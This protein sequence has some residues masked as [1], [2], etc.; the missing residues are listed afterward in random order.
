[1]SRLTPR[2]DEE[3]GGLSTHARGLRLWPA[4]ACRDQR[5]RWG[6]FS[7]RPA[8]VLWLQVLVWATVT[9]HLR[10]LPRC[11]PAPL[12]PTSMGS[13]FCPAAAAA[14]QAPHSPAQTCRASSPHATVAEFPTVHLSPPRVTSHTASLPLR[15]P[16]V[17]RL[18]TLVPGVPL[19]NAFL[20]PHGPIRLPSFSLRTASLPHVLGSP[21]PL[22]RGQA[23]GRTGGLQ[24]PCSPS[25]N[26]RG[27]E[28]GQ[29]VFVGR[30]NEE[31]TRS[32][33][34]HGPWEVEK[35]A[36]TRPVASGLLGSGQ[37]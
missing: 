29:D 23:P 1:M 21:C 30:G 17:L 19:G 10:E 14:S 32:V 20:Q 5:P 36:V 22:A 6:S 4:R 26:R 11:P 9:S 3:T 8:P 33:L 34:S 16:P 15:T 25:W 12:V 2:M 24:A 18:T 28:E 35:A 37:L 13:L 27:A 31:Q 7:V